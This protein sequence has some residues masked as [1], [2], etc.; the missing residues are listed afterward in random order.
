MKLDKILKARKSVKQF[1]KK[2]VKWDDLSDI[3]HAGTLAPS[4]GNL[5][6]W[7]F[8]IVKEKKDKLVK[9][10]PTKQQW[11]GKAPVLV[12]VCSDMEH[13]SKLFG[14]RGEALFA[15]QNCAAAIENMLLKATDLG[16][17]S[18]WVGDFDEKK[19]S[20]VIKAKKNIRPQAIIAFGYGK[21]LEEKPRHAL[22]TCIAFE[23]VGKSFKDDP[24]PV[25]SSLGKALEKLKKIK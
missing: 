7:L 13:I 23:E 22:G 6:N 9:T 5:Q 2:A 12:V 10:L 14:A 15:V 3:L 20:R 17:G 11:L 19:V 25:S 1:N 8:V 4:S 16:I 21:H 18:S 24:F